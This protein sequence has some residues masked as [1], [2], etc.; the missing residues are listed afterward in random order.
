MG[1]DGEGGGGKSMEDRV[2]LR[3]H[4]T[5]IKMLNLWSLHPN[6][7]PLHSKFLW[8]ALASA[9][10]I[11]NTIFPVQHRQDYYMFCNI[12]PKLWDKIT[13]QGIPQWCTDLNPGAAREKQRHLFALVI[14]CA[15]KAG[16]TCGAWTQPGLQGK[17]RSDHSLWCPAACLPK[18]VY[19]H[20][21][22]LV[23]GASSSFIPER[24]PGQ[25]KNSLKG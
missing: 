13:S 25:S 3:I 19:T 21:Y 17:A 12:V 16:G 4:D 9:R 14:S 23:A 18:V 15:T 1:N 7:F 11:G 24:Q 8:N 2:L 6:F 10:K 20:W 5:N 22:L